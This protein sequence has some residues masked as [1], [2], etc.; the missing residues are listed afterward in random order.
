MPRRHRAIAASTPRRRMMST[1]S[2][3]RSMN[4]SC[5]TRSSAGTACSS[6]ITCSR[7]LATVA[8]AS[9]RAGE[10]LAGAVPDHRGGVRTGVE[11]GQRGEHDRSSRRRSA[12]SGAA[13]RP[14]RSASRAG[15]GMRWQQLDRTVGA[16]LCGAVAQCGVG[17]AVEQLARRRRRTSTPDGSAIDGRY[18]SREH[19]ARRRRDD[20]CAHA[21]AMVPRRVEGA[22]VGDQGVRAVEQP[23]LDQF[24]ALRPRR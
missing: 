14:S 23:Q 3:T 1:S 9:P 7:E 15:S 18:S 22:E 10:A 12:R 11:P 13:S 19:G 17:P 6:P 21:S 20:V 2:P 16:D 24:V 5:A 8:R 4:A